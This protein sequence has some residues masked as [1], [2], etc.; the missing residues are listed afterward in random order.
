MQYPTP[1]RRI[2]EAALCVPVIPQP[3]QPRKKNSQGK[4]LCS[5]HQISAAGKMASP[6]Y[7]IT[8]KQIDGF[9]R[10]KETEEEERRLAAEKEA[11]RTKAK[12]L[13]VRL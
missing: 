1:E 4:R 3:S 8:K 6:A 12:T 9:W 10:R 5:H 2:Y 13:K 7:S 11:A